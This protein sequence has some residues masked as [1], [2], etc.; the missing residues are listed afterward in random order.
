MRTTILSLFLIPFFLLA[1]E[2][3]SYGF[4]GSKPFVTL[5]GEEKFTTIVSY[6]DDAQ[7]KNWLGEDMGASRSAS[8]YC[9]GDEFMAIN[10]SFKNGSGRVGQAVAAWISGD[11]NVFINCRFLGFQDTLYTFGK[12]VRQLYYQCYIEDTVDFIFGGSTAWFEN[13]ELHCKNRGY[14]TAASTPGQVDFG[15]I[16]NNCN[17]TG[18]KDTKSFYLG[19]PWQSYAKVIFMHCNLPKFIEG[20]DWH[21]WDKEPNEKTAYFAEYKN[22]GAGSV[23]QNRV[24]WSRLLTVREADSLNFQRV[25]RIGYQTLHLINK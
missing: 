2:V 9:H 17:V 13:Y 14:I 6:D 7:K 11:R 10:L 24:K 8:F 18:N 15:Y 22:R 21:N 12:G 4:V 1:S 3:K 20:K 5:V 25:S 19:R 23:S 16:F